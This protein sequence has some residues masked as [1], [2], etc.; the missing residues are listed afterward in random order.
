MIEPTS[1]QLAKLPK[2][3]QEHIASLSRESNMWKSAALRFSKEQT[4]SPFY[5]SD[6]VTTSET[7]KRFIPA[8]M[9]FIICEHAGVRAE[10][11]AVR[12]DDGQRLFGVEVRFVES[13]TAISCGKIAVVPRS[14]GVIQFV[15]KENLR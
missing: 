1:E 14:S 10:I 4:E 15:S 3:A 12:P 5:T 8:P 11:M 2:W 6:W 9:G 7:I 13:G